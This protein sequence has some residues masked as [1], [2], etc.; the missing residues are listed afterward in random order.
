MTY[1]VSL[2]SAERIL[3]LAFAARVSVVLYGSPG[4]GKTALV[5]RVAHAKDVPLVTLN[6]PQLDPVDLRGIPWVENRDGRPTT[7]WAPPWFMSPAEEEGILFLDE[8]T[9]APPAVAVAGM[10]LLLEH[11]IGDAALP[12]GWRVIAAGNLADHQT[13]AYDL[14]APARNRVLQLHLQP[15][16]VEWLDWAKAAGIDER[17]VRFLTGRT[18][19]LVSSTFE[20]EAFPSPRS[21]ELLSR[22]LKLTPATDT[23]DILVIAAG[24]IGAPTAAEFVEFLATNDRI[25]W[26]EEARKV[27]KDP[28]GYTL[29]EGANAQDLLKHMAETAG[30]TTIFQ[31][32]AYLMRLHGDYQE[33]YLQHAPSNVRN[34]VRQWLNL[35]EGREC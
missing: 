26:A 19:R 5:R 31:D 24:L 23:D 12:E 21:W 35:R 10:Q 18:N 1:E 3:D 28:G 33:F 2:H 11:R 29:P 4:L 16:L 13:I 27:R 15:S 25:D 34:E 6:M 17:I 20:E 7:R 30:T 9:S 32:V 8:I 22:M 14:P